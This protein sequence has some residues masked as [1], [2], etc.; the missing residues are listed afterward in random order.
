MRFA[1]LCLVVAAIYGLTFFGSFSTADVIRNDRNPQAYV[2]LGAQPKYAA[3]GRLDITQP[4]GKYIGSGTLISPGWVLTAAHCVD[5]ASALSFTLAGTTYVA[6]GWLPYPQWK[7]KLTAGYDIGLVHLASAAAGVTPAKRFTGA[8]ELGLKG[9]FVGY[10]MT[11]TGLT[12]AKTFDGLKRGAENVL[13]TYYTERRTTNNRILLAD[14]DNPANRRDNLFGS[15][16]PLNLEGLIA[17]GDSG[18][19]LFVD[20]GTGAFLAGVHSFVGAYD[21]NPNSDYGDFSGDTRVAS[22]NNWID[23]ILSGGPATGLGTGSGTSTT[24]SGSVK[25]QNGI[26]PI[27][28][29]ATLSLLV[30]GGLLILR[31]RKRGAPN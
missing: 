1:K 26:E 25:A 5:K 30:L 12:G 3:V 13:D 16:T 28:E 20:I 27:P 14:F 7:G 29:P 11:G 10:G 31:R 17:P 9:T 21:G 8:N 2:D 22:F 6:S 24:G 15:P 19:G 4:S 23:Q 18:G